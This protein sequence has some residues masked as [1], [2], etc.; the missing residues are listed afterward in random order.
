MHEIAKPPK[1][2]IHRDEII[3]SDER[4]AELLC[5]WEL[6]GK[7]R[8][9]RVVERPGWGYS[10]KRGCMQPRFATNVQHNRDVGVTSLLAMDEFLPQAGWFQAAR[11]LQLTQE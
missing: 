6:T 3:D 4:H 10:P 1:P 5:I 7:C 8:G 2:K 9:S 11:S